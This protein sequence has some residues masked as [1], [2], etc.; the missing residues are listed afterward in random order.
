MSWRQTKF[1]AKLYINDSNVHSG[2]GLTQQE[3]SALIDR[4]KE[5]ST[6]I[7]GIVELHIIMCGGSHN[8][9]IDAYDT[10]SGGIFDNGKQ[11]CQGDYETN[12]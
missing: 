11:I 10:V 6:N 8:K 4:D 12:D 2:K 1:A 7:R 9:H 5:L 3:L